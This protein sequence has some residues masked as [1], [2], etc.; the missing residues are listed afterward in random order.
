MYCTGILLNIISPSSAAWADCPRETINRSKPL[1]SHAR[2]DNQGVCC[3]GTD[4]AC[5]GAIA[6]PPHTSGT[7]FMF[8]IDFCPAKKVD[9]NRLI[10][11][12]VTDYW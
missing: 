4:F 6:L 8:A 7:D 10:A 3:K 2:P 9:N 5:R 1:H 11:Q 12:S